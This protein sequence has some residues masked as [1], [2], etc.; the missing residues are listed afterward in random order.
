L[1][2]VKSEGHARMKSLIHGKCVI[3]E[4]MVPTSPPNEKRAV[5]IARVWHVPK[6]PENRCLTGKQANTKH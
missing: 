3:N 2:P 6:G 5:S 4:R 1:I